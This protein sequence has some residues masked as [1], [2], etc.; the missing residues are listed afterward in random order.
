MTAIRR[1]SANAKW[2]MLQRILE[3][4]LRFV[5]NAWMIRYLG[6]EDFGLYSYAL[7]YFYLFANVATLGL[8][9]I[10]VRDLSR[11]AHPAGELLATAFML[12]VVAS[13]S[14]FLLLVTIV[15]L[16]EHSLITRVVVLISGAQLLFSPANVVDLLFQSEVRLRHVALSRIGVALVFAAGQAYCILAGQGLISFVI[17]LLAQSLLMAT[18]LLACLQLSLTKTRPWRV[19]REVAVRMLREAW[20]MLLA[21]LA[22]SVYMRIDQLILGNMVGDVA[23]GIYGAAAKVSEVWYFVPTALVTAVFPVIVRLRASASADYHNRSVQVLYD[24]LVLYSYGIVLLTIVGAPW[25]IAVLF[26]PEYAA[27]SNVLR[28]HICSLV[29]LSISIVNLS[30]LVAEAKGIYMMYMTTLGAILNVATNVLL[31]PAFAEIGAAWATVVSYLVAAYASSFLFPALRHGMTRH[32]TKAL[33]APF[34][35][36]SVVRSLRYVAEASQPNQR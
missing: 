4:V 25:I 23:V 19:N 3:L 6:P 9:Q 13:I 32:M 26:G 7:S 11:G 5:L 16:T 18:A 21:G 27:S 15:L 36:G 20:P 31:I 17:L 1:I 14:S 8:D 22:I 30:W 35:I 12:R 28:I 2:L 33:L 29:F 10:I 24:V 34:R